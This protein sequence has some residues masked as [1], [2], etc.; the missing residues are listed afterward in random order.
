MDINCKLD[1]VC[2]ECDRMIIYFNPHHDKVTTTYDMLVCFATLTRLEIRNKCLSTVRC[3]TRPK[4]G[5]VVFVG[6]STVPTIRLSK[7][8]LDNRETHSP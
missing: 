1:Q 7:R 6:V 8:T 2:G 4:K 5:D 3:H